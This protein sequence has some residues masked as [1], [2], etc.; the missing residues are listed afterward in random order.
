M[1]KLEVF[2]AMVLVAAVIVTV[3]GAGLTFLGWQA[4]RLLIHLME[5]IPR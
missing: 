1:T 3:A 2:G 5:Q 4:L